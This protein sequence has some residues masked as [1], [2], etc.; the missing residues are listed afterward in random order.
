[1]V[2]RHIRA[3]L[4]IGAAAFSGWVYAQ[5]GPP[6]DAPRLPDYRGWTHVKSVLIGPK[7]AAFATEGG[8]HHIYANEKAME[9]LR[10]GRFPDGSTLIYDLLEVKEADGVTSEGSRRRIDVMVKDDA[11]NRDTGGWDFRQFRGAGRR[12][13][14]LTPEQR[15]SCFQCHERRKDRGF[16][17]S[18]FR[19]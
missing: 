4:T 9:G 14:E 11:H 16:V 1:M 7:S 5:A 3:W 8:I 15:A 12:D 17:F 10:T 2:T 13:A 18:A 19:E 6:D